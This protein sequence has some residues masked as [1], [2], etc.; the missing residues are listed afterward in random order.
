LLFLY[1]LLIPIQILFQLLSYSCYKD[2]EGKTFFNPSK[3]APNQSKDIKKSQKE[4]IC[5]QGLSNV[6]DVVCGSAFNIAR[7]VVF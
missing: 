1:S 2:K 7:L 5:I 6:V 3:S 4:P